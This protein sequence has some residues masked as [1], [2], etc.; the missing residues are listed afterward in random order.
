MNAKDS[1]AFCAL[2][3]PSEISRLGM[4]IKPKLYI[5][6]AAA[7]NLYGYNDFTKYLKRLNNLA[8]GQRQKKKKR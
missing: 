8:A 5:R 6:S 4:N 3:I 7:N 1:P 2:I